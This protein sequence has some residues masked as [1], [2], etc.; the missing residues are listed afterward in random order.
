MAAAAG[1]APAAKALNRRAD[2]LLHHAPATL[3]LSAQTAQL[4]GD[5]GAAR[6]RFQEMLEH[7]ETEF[8]G[9][10]GLLAQ[11]IKDGDSRDRAQARAARL[12]APAEHA[13]GADHAVRPADPGG[14]LDRGA[15]HG[16]RHGAPQADRRADRDPAARDPVP[17][18]SGGDRAPGRPYAALDM[19]RKAHKLLPSLAPLAVQASRARRADPTSPGCAQD[20]RGGV[21]GQAASGDRQ[22][23]SRPRRQ[24]AAGRA[25][26]A[27]RAPAPAEPE[28]V[29][30]DLALAEQAI[31]ARQWPAA[32][33]ALE[34]ARKRGPTASVYRLL[35][36]VEQAEGDGEK[37]R[38]WLAKAVD[39]P[40]DRPGSARPPGEV[41]AHWSAFGPDGRF[42]SLRWG[43]PPKIVPLLG[44][45]HA[46]LIPPSPE[47]APHA[48]VP[49][50][51]ETTPVREAKLTPRERA[52]S[53]RRRARAG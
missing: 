46:E 38:V 9:L 28:H 30:S 37:A 47:A 26:Q 19:A 10:R 25:P 1:D 6:Q 36:E 12:S 48:P 4:E 3:L 41:R 23:L 31:A 20:A 50:V 53:V 16:R 5:E 39:A 24:G 27:G 51:P 2:K 34:R 52:A 13:L 44:D 15:E 22:G 11:A 40:P 18:A 8:L 14:A 42:D 45:E 29:E 35:A 33:T 32:R 43:S 21:A 17:P 49:M 7:Q